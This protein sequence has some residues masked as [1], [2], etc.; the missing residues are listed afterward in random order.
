MNRVIIIVGVILV[1]IT[2][3]FSHYST[4]ERLREVESNQLFIDSIRQY[5]NSQYEM[6]SI[7]SN[8]GWVK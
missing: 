3:I 4:E 8:I 7:N 1:F 2:C 5:N 6:D